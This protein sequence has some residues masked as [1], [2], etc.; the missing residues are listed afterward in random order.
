MLVVGALK[1]SKIMATVKEQL[2]R[3]C[4]TSSGGIARSTQVESSADERSDKE[5]NF[6]NTSWIRS[7]QERHV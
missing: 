5:T 6:P 2:Q 3:C 1:D 4:W 7:L